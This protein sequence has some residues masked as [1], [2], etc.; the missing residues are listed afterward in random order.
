M[1]RFGTSSSSFQESTLVVS[2][3]PLAVPFV[4]D[5][6]PRAPYVPIPLSARLGLFGILKFLAGRLHSRSVL[7]NNDDEQVVEAG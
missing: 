2:P 6:P 1:T 7:E 3:P 4:V 5:A